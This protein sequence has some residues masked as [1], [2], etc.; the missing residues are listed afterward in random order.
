MAPERS[1][2]NP[3]MPDGNKKV[4]LTLTNLKLSPAGLFE[5]L[6]NFLLPPGIN[7]LTA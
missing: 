6:W 1:L 4:T 3:L 5:C 7:G 2:F